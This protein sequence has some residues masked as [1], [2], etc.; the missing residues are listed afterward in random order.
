MKT[1]TIRS[2][3]DRENISPEEFNFINLDI[4]GV[5]LKALKGL[6]DYIKN[7][8]YIYTEINTGEVYKENNTLKE[9]DDFLNSHGFERVETEITPFEWGDA[10][11]IRK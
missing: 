5:E 2:L 1:S 8:K 6:G 7:I 11:Y 4:Q 9:M 10:F 3:M